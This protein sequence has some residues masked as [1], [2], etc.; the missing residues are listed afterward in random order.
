LL[1]SIALVVFS[2]DQLTKAWIF[3][4]LPLG[5]YFYP[6]SI[7]VVEGFFYIVHIGNEGAAWGMLSGYS[8][9]LALF[10]LVALYGIYK[11]RHTL[12]LNRPVMQLAFGLLVG[13]IVGNLV[14]RLIHGHV[15]DFLDFHFPF[16]IPVIMPTGRYPSFN[17]ADC[18]IVIGVFIY[19]G[20]SFLAP[21]QQ[22]GD[23]EPDER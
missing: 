2:L 1:F 16:Q 21:A 9:W 6:D 5:S 10:A 17:I 23:E 15:I 4:N 8:G 13:G 19:I 22:D 11:I 18:G 3:N 12:E 14:D 7:E 20:V